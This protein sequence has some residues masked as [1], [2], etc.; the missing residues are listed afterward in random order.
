MTCMTEKDNAVKN[1]E[2]TTNLVENEIINKYKV[3]IY[4]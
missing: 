1:F 2:E 4:S 3:R